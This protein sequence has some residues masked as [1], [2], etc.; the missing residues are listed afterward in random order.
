MTSTFEKKI[1]KMAN[2]ATF[3]GWALCIFNNGQFFTQFQNVVGATAS[4][5]AMVAIADCQ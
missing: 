4:Y 5:Q 1:M 3:I 2:F